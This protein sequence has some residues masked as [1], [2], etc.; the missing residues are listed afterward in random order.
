MKDVVLKYTCIGIASVLM[1][2]ISDI[3]GAQVIYGLDKAQ[4]FNASRHG[5]FTV[6]AGSFRNEQN[7]H[8]LKEKLAAQLHYAVHVKSSRQYYLV[9]IGPLSSSSIVREVGSS[10]TTHFAKITQQHTGKINPKVTHAPLARKPAP[11]PVRPTALSTTSS[12]LVEK[13]GKTMHSFDQFIP[14]KTNWYAGIGVGGQ[15]PTLNSSVTVHNGSDFPVPLNQDVYST[16]NNSQVFLGVS[17]GRR[18][19]NNNFWLSALSFGVLYEH[20][21]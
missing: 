15:F 21:F 2:G 14:T 13:T 18:W 8:R 16:S 19:Q 10:Q 9:L 1:V 4:H 6:Q 20:F 7:A 12:Q 3:V 17:A 11:L 5:P